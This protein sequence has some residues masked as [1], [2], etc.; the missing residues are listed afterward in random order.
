[1]VSGGD[2]M[3]PDPNHSAQ[4][5]ARQFLERF[6]DTFGVM[7][8]H[9]DEFL[10]ARRYCGSPFLGRAWCDAMYAGKGPM[11][12][13]Y[14]H[15]YA[16]NEL[17]W[18][19][20]GLGA[21]WERPDLSHFHDHFTRDGRAQPAYWSTVKRHDLHDCLLYYA[22]VHEGFPGHEPRPGLPFADRS[23]ARSPAMLDPKEMLVLADQR[24]LRVALDNPFA[25]ALSEGLRRAARDGHERVALYGFGFHTQVGAAA[26][27][28]PPVAID[29]IIDDNAANHARRPWGIPIVSRDA[30][31]RRNFSAIVLS[32]NSVEDRLWDNTQELRERGIRVYRLYA[33]NT[34]AD[35]GATPAPALNHA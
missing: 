34:P 19:A 5:L 13:A 32:G 29:C 16:D 17:Y 3:L 24:L 25:T 30:A 21:L 18:L 2:D 11:Y 20:K 22:R 33:R 31:H 28:E 7:Q 4:E 8:P 10:A 23:L 9:G 35:D 1:V 14:H 26:L 27:C 15:N 12:G 6:P